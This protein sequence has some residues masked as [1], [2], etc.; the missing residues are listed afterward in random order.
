MQERFQTLGFRALSFEIRKEPFLCVNLSLQPNFHLQA[1]VNLATSQAHVVTV[2]HGHAKRSSTELTGAAKAAGFPA[3]E[4]WVTDR[5]DRRVVL[6][7]QG[8]K[9]RDTRYCEYHTG[10]YRWIPGSV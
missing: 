4:L 8:L 7:V 10:A 2:A 6:D 9:V 5:E 1:S 3:R